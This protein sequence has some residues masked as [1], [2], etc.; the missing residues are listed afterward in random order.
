MRSVTLQVWSDGAWLLTASEPGRAPAVIASGAPLTNVRI[1][2]GADYFRDEAGPHW[3]GEDPVREARRN[4][5]TAAVTSTWIA[6]FLEER[7]PGQ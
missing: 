4:A 6:A 2:R 7:K 5:I 3:L 1:R